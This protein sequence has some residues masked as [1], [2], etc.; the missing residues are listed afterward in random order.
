MRFCNLGK[1]LLARSKNKFLQ[2]TQKVSIVFCSMLLLLSYGSFAQEQP[3]S[4][5]RDFWLMFNSNLSGNGENVDLFIASDIA[6]SGSVEI[7]GLGF[8]ALFNVTPGLVTTVDL[9]LNARAVGGDTISNLGIHVMSEKEVTVY[10]LNQR[11]STTDAFLG[12]P[13][14]ILGTE[15]INLGFANTNV[16]NA[17][18]FG[19]VATQDTTTVTITPSVTTGS[20]LIGVPYDIV[21]NQGQTYQLRN[22]N[23]APAD[24]SGTIIESD[25][26]IGVFGGHQCANIPTGNTVACDHI[27][28]MLPPVSTWGTS[29]VTFPLATRLNGDTFRIMAAQDATSVSINGVVVATLDRAKIFQTLLTEPSVITT[30]KPVLVAQYSNGTS[31][32]SVTS[33]PFEVIVPPF[34]QFLASYT[35]STPATGFRFNFVNVVV[36]NAA[37]GTVSLDGVLIPAADYSAIAGSGFSGVAVSVELGSH[38]LSGPIPFGLTSYGFDDADSYGYVGGLALAEIS[39]LTNLTISPLTAVNQINTEHCVVATTLD[40]NAIPLLGIRVDFAV[41][42]VTTTSGFVFTDASGESE[43]CYTGTTVGVDSIVASVGNLSASA[44]KEW[45]D[46]T[47]PALRCD[48][49]LDGQVDSLDI[50]LIGS[51]RNAPVTPGIAALDIDN[52][53]FVNANDARKC[54]LECTNARCAI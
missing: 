38:S 22:T 39:N 31:F 41:S 8:T 26:P 4:K 32:D 53:G 37:V 20:R 30:D 29:F 11:D 2:I 16:V 10:G 49:N 50:R 5:G 17:T 13:T 6:T 44:S 54:V 14:D 12:L 51:Y 40:Q 28:E 35:I 3:D 18:Q 15:Y 23:A 21:L 1:Q 7:P 34:E 52:N 9:P 19:V 24:L 42:G 48:A 46:E 25:K 36:P 45:I 43:F 33:D 27:V 47:P